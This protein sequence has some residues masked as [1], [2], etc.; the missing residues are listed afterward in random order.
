MPTAPSREARGE[1]CRAPPKRVGSAGRR[2]WFAARV[3]STWL[4]LGWA[5]REAHS[6]CP[7]PAEGVQRVPTS[8]LWKCAR[9][10]ERR[11]RPERRDLTPLPQLGKSSSQQSPLERLGSLASRAQWGPAPL[12]AGRAAGSGGHATVRVGRADSG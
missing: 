8:S 3:E 12:E 11:G 10:G 7:G 6:A 9:R 2:A 5:A 4:L 1:G